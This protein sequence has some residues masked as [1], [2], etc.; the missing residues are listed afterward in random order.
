MGEEQNRI[1]NEI[2]QECVGNELSVDSKN[3]DV[4][5]FEVSP[6]A[7]HGDNFASVVKLVDFKFKL[8]EEDRTHSY[9]YKEVPYNE[10]REKF[11]RQVIRCT[12]I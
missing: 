5:S 6:G 4:T 8:N 2:L 7:A 12:Y 9:I 11:V 1:T 10:M 3:V